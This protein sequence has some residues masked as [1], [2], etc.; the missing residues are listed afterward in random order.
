MSFAVISYGGGGAK[1]GNV[2]MRY[3]E[4]DVN[5]NSSLALGRE[6]SLRTIT[7]EKSDMQS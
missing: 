6:W 5:R 2:P 3:S 4:M 7:R 1:T